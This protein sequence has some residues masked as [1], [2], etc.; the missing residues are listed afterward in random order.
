MKEKIKDAFMFLMLL[1]LV[2][3]VF[4]VPQSCITVAIKDGINQSVVGGPPC[5]WFDKDKK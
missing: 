4:L 3:L 5:V 1:L 2:A